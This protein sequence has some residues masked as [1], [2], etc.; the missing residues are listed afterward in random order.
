MF[1]CACV[2]SCE[3]AC[4]YESKQ[5][6]VYHR[7]IERVSANVC[8]LVCGYISARSVCE[9]ACVCARLDAHA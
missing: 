3:C 7:C 4:G 1:A 6:F 5:Y 2:F 8:V 9:G